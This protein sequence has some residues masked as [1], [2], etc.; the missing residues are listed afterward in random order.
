MWICCKLFV[1]L[2]IDGTIKI[3]ICIVALDALIVYSMLYINYDNINEKRLSFT[4]ALY[5]LFLTPS[6]LAAT[7]VS[8]FVWLSLSSYNAQLDSVMRGL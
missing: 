1:L 2:V 6:W 7:S 4:A 3:N 8:A 5:K